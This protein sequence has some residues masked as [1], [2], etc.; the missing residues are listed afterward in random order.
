MFCQQN[1][2]LFKTTVSTKQAATHSDSPRLNSTA[3]CLSDASEVTPTAGKRK[4]PPGGVRR[5]LQRV[6]H[7]LLALVDAVHPDVHGVLALAQVA[8]HHH[9]GASL[10]QS[11]TPTMFTWTDERVRPTRFHPFTLFWSIHCYMSDRVSCFIHLSTH[12]HY[13]TRAHVR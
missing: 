13:F 2:C 4:P 9:C 1:S 6:V 12:S 5:E 3:T 7:S 11:D 10:A 8:L